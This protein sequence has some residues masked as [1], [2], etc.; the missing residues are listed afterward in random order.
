[1]KIT[2]S[3]RAAVLLAAMAVTN[4]G[5]MAVPIVA[6]ANLLHNTGSMNITL[7]GHGDAV[8]AFREAVNKSGGMVTQST[9]DYALGEFRDNAVRVEIQVVG[10]KQ[11]RIMMKGSSNT[12]VAR[13]WE[14]EDGIGNTTTK[15]A[16]LM[17]GAG[18]QITAKARDRA[19]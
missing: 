2:S 16:E 12:T 13:S 14:F 18:F 6:G 8:V 1:M 4:A 19:I 17:A 9:K 7:E 5:C 15:V 10:E 11:Q 3:F